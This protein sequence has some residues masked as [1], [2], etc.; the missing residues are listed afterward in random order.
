MQTPFLRAGNSCFNLGTGIL[1]LST[2]SSECYE[3]FF[4]QQSNCYGNHKNQSR[5][6][7]TSKPSSTMVSAQVCYKVPI[8]MGP[9][10]PIFITQT[11]MKYLFSK[12]NFRDQSVPEH[13]RDFS[14]PL[15]KTFI[16]C[17][18]YHICHT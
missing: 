16:T 15:L 6:S 17:S 1:E 7:I 14:I 12:G 3:H 4:T 18:V 10:P 13:F 5:S 11:G 2:H 8:S 9:I